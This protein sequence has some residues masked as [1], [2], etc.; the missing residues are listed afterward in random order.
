MRVL[1]AEDE[2]SLNK[3]IRKTLQDNGYAV[4]GVFDGNDALD[5]LSS[6]VYDAAVLD[7]MMP[8]MD[9]FE[10]LRRY[11]GE[12]GM[13][14]VIFLTAR[15][16]IKDRVDGL[17]TGAD[18]YLVKPFSFDE[19]LAR[20]RGLLRRSVSRSVSDVLCV[21]DLVLDRAKRTVVRAGRPVML[22][23]KEFA[24]LEYMMVN[25]GIVLGRE[26]FLTHAWDYGYGGESNVIDVYIRYLRKKIDDG[27]EKKLIH[28]I[29]GAGYVLKKEQ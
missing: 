27:C 4:D 16:S 5:Y 6:G 19:L 28:T 20:I 11:R 18:D 7:V 25:E 23:S 12:G 13:T 22:S 17:D 8:G 24:I 29:R 15:D 21:D 9:G 10:V 2:K 1:V 26:D 3:V 14:P